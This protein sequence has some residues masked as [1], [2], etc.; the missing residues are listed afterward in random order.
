[1]T[2]QPCLVGRRGRGGFGTVTTGVVQGEAA[3]SAR[4]ARAVQPAFP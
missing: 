3:I 1:M 4:A 2:F